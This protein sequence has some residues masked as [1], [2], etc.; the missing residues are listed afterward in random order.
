MTISTYTEPVSKL[1]SYGDCRN[2][3]EW[4]DYLELGFAREHVPDLIGMAT[5]EELNWADSD[6]L[7]VWAPIHAWRALGQLHS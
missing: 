2:F 4:P 3:K 5:D 7:E 6:S 1:L